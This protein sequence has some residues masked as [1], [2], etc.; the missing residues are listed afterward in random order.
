MKPRRTTLLVSIHFWFCFI[1]ST[2]AADVSLSI[3]VANPAHPIS[4]R[5]YGIF[6]EDINFGGDGGLHAELVKNGSLEFPQRLMGWSASPH[7]LAK[8]DVQVSHETPAFATNPHYLRLRST[9]V[10]TSAN[11]EGF[12]GIGVRAGE[13]Y[14]FSAHTRADSRE[15]QPARR[16]GYSRRPNARGH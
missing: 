4:P 14:L 2:I 1:C 10:P 11:N 15:C 9:S 7:N 3:D 13:R 5:L 12:R 8:A 6:F 16:P